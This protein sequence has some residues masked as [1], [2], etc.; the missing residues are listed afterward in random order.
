MLYPAPLRAPQTLTRKALFEQRCVAVTAG[1]HVQRTRGR[2]KAVFCSGCP[3]FGRLWCQAVLLA[4]CLVC[5][6]PEAQCCSVLSVQ[7]DLVSQHWAGRHECQCDFERDS[8]TVM[9]CTTP[10]TCHPCAAPAPHVTLHGTD[11]VHTAGPCCCCCT[12]YPICPSR[13]LPPLLCVVSCVF[14]IVGLVLCSVCCLP[15]LLAWV[16]LLTS[17]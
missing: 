12:A 6:Q 4:F 9:R 10:P 8:V 16:A 14:C 2:A 13:V 3:P 1:V 7:K 11:A 17:L 5:Q 15:T